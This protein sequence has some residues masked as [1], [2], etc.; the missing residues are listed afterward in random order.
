MKVKFLSLIQISTCQLSVIEKVRHQYFL[1]FFSC[2]SLFF[3]L[4]FYHGLIRLLLSFIG[5]LLVTVFSSLLSFF[6]HFINSKA[7]HRARIGEKGDEIHLT[8]RLAII[9]KSE[10]N[11]SS[12]K[13]SFLTERNIFFVFFVNNKLFLHQPFHFVF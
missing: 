2:S 12:R 11:L 1:D 4:F 3:L 7:I 5:I 8:D 13:V 6:L 9:S 10:G